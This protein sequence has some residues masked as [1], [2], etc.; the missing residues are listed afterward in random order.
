MPNKY[1][2]KFIFLFLLVFGIA[3]LVPSNAN[4]QQCSGSASCC[5]SYD[6]ECFPVGCDSTGK[7]P[8]KPPCTSCIRGACNN[9]RNTSC[10]ELL[11]PPDCDT[12]PNIP[13]YC[14]GGFA[15]NCSNPAT[16][17]PPSCTTADGICL[18]AGGTCCS[19]ASHSDGACSS[20]VK[21]GP[22]PGGTPP[23][24]VG[25]CSGD[26]FL[27]LNNCGEVGRQPVSGTCSNGGLCCGFVG[28]GSSCTATLS[29]PSTVEV[30]TTATYRAYGPGVPDGWYHYW[31]GSVWWNG[32]PYPPYSGSGPNGWDGSGPNGLVNFTPVL[33]GNYTI[34][35]NVKEGDWTATNIACSASM[36]V[37]IIPAPPACTVTIPNV[38]VSSGWP[39]SIQ[40][41][42]NV[43]R[44]STVSASYVSGNAAI[45]SVIPA[46]TAVA[47]YGTDVNG[48]SAGNTTVTVTINMT[49]GSTCTDTSNVNVVAGSA[50]WQVNGGDVITNNN[51]MSTLPGGFKFILDGSGGFPGN[52]IYGGTT[53]LTK[54]TVSSTGWLGNTP[55]QGRN[56]NFDYFNSI[57]S[58]DI[59]WNTLVGP[60]APDLNSG[61]NISPDGYYYYKTSSAGGLTI[62]A[63]ALSRK[64]VV[65]VSPTG[66]LGEDL[67]I[68]GNITITNP[69][70]G[71]FMAVVSGDTV[72][73]PTVT[74]I[75]GLYETDGT[76]DTGT[77]INPLT[78]E[79][80]VI[81]WGT[82][83]LQR[84]LGAA[85]DTTP[86]ETFKFDPSLSVLFP[87][88]LIRDSVSW[89]EVIP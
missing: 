15:V 88:S 56:Y 1:L 32:P 28:G 81:A 51:I 58:T 6:E 63:L 8:T 57:A 45:A 59:V 25:N 18:P 2:L 46:A 26:C 41:T 38:V 7:D 87:R 10:S 13:S 31:G 9:T 62:N 76:F 52:A 4:A 66:G 82:V 55:Y 43:V 19:G 54:T 77:G 29:G 35:W 64:V 84:D 24:P 83:N 73:S 14:Q 47:P 68:S 27:G 49:D 34:Q 40:P 80:S 75:E 42:I 30:G 70:T 60:V 17:A 67:N 44:G 74:N 50:W 78:V 53:N 61:G 79:G 48:I 86:A 3:I 36:P 23:P 72:I 22:A 12:L 37:T 69:G 65:F 89:Q 33:T 16:P 85:N 5:T 11:D 20:G 71:F 21:C 39:Q